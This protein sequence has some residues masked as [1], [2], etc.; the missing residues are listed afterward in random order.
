MLWVWTTIIGGATTYAHSAW[1]NTTR[2]LQSQ[3]RTRERGWVN[4]RHPDSSLVDLE[5]ISDEGVEV[6]V[7]VGEIVEGE[8]LPVPR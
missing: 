8:L 2:G 7:R 4:S 6:D 5:E 1:S 3:R